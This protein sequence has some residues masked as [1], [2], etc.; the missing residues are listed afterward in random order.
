MLFAFPSPWSFRSHLLIDRLHHRL[1][2]VVE[3]R[4]LV[5]EIPGTVRKALRLVVL[6]GVEH[7]HSVRLWGRG[8]RVT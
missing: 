2:D 5:A 7:A 3:L 8:G 6:F 4:D 1:D